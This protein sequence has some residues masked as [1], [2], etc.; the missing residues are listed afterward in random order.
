MG[1]SYFRFVT[2]HAF[3]TDRQTDRQACLS[4]IVRCITCS[5]TVKIVGR[6]L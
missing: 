4:N 2:M 3:L 6:H 1:T 5:R